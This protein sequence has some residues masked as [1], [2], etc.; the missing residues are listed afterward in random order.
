MDEPKLLKGAVSVDDRG[1]VS[2]VNDFDFAGVK[3]FYMI[4]NHRQGF[5]RAWHG[6]KH[7]AKY[8]TV[9]KGSALICGVQVDNWTNPSKELKVHRFVLSEKNPMVLYLPAGFANGAMSLT[10]DAQIMVFS[11]SALQESLQ[12]DI[13]FESH[14]WDPW[15][16]EER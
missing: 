10:E 12:D 8:F 11:T 16:I 9:V 13:R 1:S 15:Q 3:R 7:E 2:F 6:H 5:I 4:R 14:Y